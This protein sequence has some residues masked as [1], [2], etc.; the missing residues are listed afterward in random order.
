MAADSSWIIGIQMTKFGKHPGKD[1]VDLASEAALV[2]AQ[3]R[4]K[5]IGVLALV[6]AMNTNA[7]IGQQLQKQIGQT[8]SPPTS[9]WQAAMIA[10]ARS[11]PR[12]VGAC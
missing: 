7:G 11:A 5:D 3:V 1:T 10:P 8:E 6:S 2:D 9:R 12:R 4:M